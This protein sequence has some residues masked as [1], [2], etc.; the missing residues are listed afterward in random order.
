VIVES[1]LA[2]FLDVLNLGALGLILYLWLTG[3]LTRPADC[4]NRVL[5]AERERDAALTE[6]DTA[7]DTLAQVRADRDTW[8]EACMI[9]AESRQ[10]ADLLNRQL[11]E[12]SSMVVDIVD[13][14]R[15]LAT[16][17][18]GKEKG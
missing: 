16:G 10:I 7:L 15:D 6:R 8:R 9:N 18:A 14:L 12:S 5:A 1:E 2:P 13:V 17:S 11:V 3:K 4:D